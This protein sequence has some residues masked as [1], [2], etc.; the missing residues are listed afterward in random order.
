MRTTAPITA[1]VQ[2][3]ILAGLVCWAALVGAQ[4]LTISI[5]FDV[6]AGLPRY[7]NPIFWAL[8]SIRLGIAAAPVLAILVWPDRHRLAEAW[9]RQRMGHDLQRP[10]AVNLAL[11]ALVATAAIGLSRSVQPGVGLSWGLMAGFGLLLGLH[12]LSLFAILMPLGGWARLIRDWRWP[13]LSSLAAA[14]AMLLLAEASL[15]LW[16]ALSQA[17]LGLSSLILGLYESDVTVDA[18]AQSI[19][20]G[21]FTV[22]VSE[23][24]SGYEGLALVSVFVSVQLALLRH[25]LRFPA[26]FLLYPIGLG[27]IWLFNSVRIAAL[28]SIGAHISPQMAVMGFHS[29]AGWI[30]FLLVAVM[31]MGL[32]GWMG[33]LKPDPATVP[34][35]N[36]PAAPTADHTTAYLAPFIGL[37]LGSIAMSAAVPHD[38]PLYILKA[39]MVAVALWLWRHSLSE[40]RPRL[41]VEPLAVGMLV[42]FA[43]IATDP[44][45]GS[46]SA[47][48]TWLAEIGPMAAAAWLLIRGIGTVLLVP[49][50]EEI[51]FRGYVYRRMIA[52]NFMRVAPTHLSLAALVVSSVVFGVLHDRWLSATLAGAVFAVVLIRSGRPGDAIV[53]HATANALIF[54]WALGFGQWS[55]L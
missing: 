38:R 29:Q 2:V 50:A 36:S 14:V 6:D 10:L 13:L 42:G 1:H 21:R 11:F 4:G 55:L 24:C 22:I 12:L 44:A 52:P 3:S 16:P 27:S 23:A 46:G 25:R 7:S 51:A 54:A 40:W 28:T 48:A 37:M 32:P 19:R 41:A 43:W 17:T 9:Q 18:A 30:A 39:L 45:V 5:L 15:L 49:A 33:L 47:L 26:A 53:C 34:H 20:I 35:G 8:S 31:L